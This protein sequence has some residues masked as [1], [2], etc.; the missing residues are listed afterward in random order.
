M[1][2]TWVSPQICHGYLH[3]QAFCK[4]SLM[5]GLSPLEHIPCSHFR[6]QGSTR[7]SPQ[8]TD[9]FSLFHLSL[10]FHLSQSCLLCCFKGSVKFCNKK[11]SCRI[12]S[13]IKF[14]LP[15]L[16]RGRSFLV[17]I[18]W[19]RCTRDYT[20]IPQQGKEIAEH[21]SFPTG[22]INALPGIGVGDP[23]ETQ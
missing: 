5:P 14:S 1:L 6:M 23:W 17:Y 3:L 2:V 7:P 13:V 9:A 11:Y 21:Y 20:L 10:S 19:V 8:L 12:Y 22:S 15:L 16:G 4:F 18:K